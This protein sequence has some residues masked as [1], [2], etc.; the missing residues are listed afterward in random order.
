MVNF[1]IHVRKDGKLF[2]A[3]CQRL[4]VQVTDKTETD[5]IKRARDA[6]ISVL[7][8]AI[9]DLG[10]Q[11][12]AEEA[13]EIEAPAFYPDEVIPDVD[14]E[15]EVLGSMK[16]K[17]RRQGSTRTI[18]GHSCTQENRA[19]IVSYASKVDYFTTK[20]LVTA[21]G[22]DPTDAAN[23]IFRMEKQGILERIERGVY[24]LRK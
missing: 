14:V 22:L 1:G 6:A 8:Q 13:A 24:A 16:A 19:T 11:T 12:S 5:A 2:H 17:R 10:S 18:K 7:R 20:E 23:L 15:L 3:S 21:T 9:V 4:G